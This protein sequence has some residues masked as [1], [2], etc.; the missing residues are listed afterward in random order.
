M[1]QLGKQ[2]SLHIP[3]LFP[4]LFKLPIATFVFRTY[5]VEVAVSKAVF[6]KGG[7]NQRH[8]ELLLRVF[9]LR[10]TH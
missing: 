2:I 4:M 5:V 6:E 10:F 8:D 1:I 9:R 3:E 7:Q